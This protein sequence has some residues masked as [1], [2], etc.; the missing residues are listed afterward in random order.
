MRRRILLE[1]ERKSMLIIIHCFYN[2]IFAAYD[3]R[4]HQDSPRLWCWDTILEIPRFYEY[5]EK[6]C[7]SC[8]TIF[9][10]ISLSIQPHNTN[11]DLYTNRLHRPPSFYPVLREPA[12]WLTDNF[13]I[14]PGGSHTGQASRNKL[15]ILADGMYL[16]LFN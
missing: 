3:L 13:T 2:R 9:I 1:F 14:T 4:L 8:S 10:N 11:H 6:Y 5:A 12:P 7:I 15:I 16:K